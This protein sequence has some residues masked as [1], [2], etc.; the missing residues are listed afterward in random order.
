Y[1]ALEGERGLTV[2]WIEVCCNEDGV[3]LSSHCHI[4]LDIL[5]GFVYLSAGLTV[6]IVVVPFPQSPLLVRGLHTRPACW[7]YVANRIVPNI[8]I[9]VPALGISGIDVRTVVSGNEPSHV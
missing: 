7:V 4:G 3:R 8:C 9:K 5:L 1:E 2:E 6:A